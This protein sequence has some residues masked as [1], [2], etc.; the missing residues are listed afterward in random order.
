M[1]NVMVMALDSSSF[2]ICTWDKRFFFKTLSKAIF[3]LSFAFLVY[4]FILQMHLLHRVLSVYV[5]CYFLVPFVSC[6]IRLIH[7]SKM[8]NW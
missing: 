3:N 6:Q 1:R 7:I 4:G 8:D 5:R 2:L